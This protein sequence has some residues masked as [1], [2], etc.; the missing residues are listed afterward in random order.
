MWRDIYSYTYHERKY[1]QEAEVK[2]ER[3]HFVSFCEITNKRNY[4]IASK[5]TETSRYST[6]VLFSLFKFVFPLCYLLLSVF[7]FRPFFE[8][9]RKGRGAWTKMPTRRFVRKN[10][11]LKLT[12]F[13]IFCSFVVQRVVAWLRSSKIFCWFCFW[14]CFFTCLFRLLLDS[15]CWFIWFSKIVN[16]IKPRQ[17]R[18]NEYSNERERDKMRVSPGE[19]KG[20]RRE[21]ERERARKYACVTTARVERE[22]V[23]QRE[24]ERET[25]IQD[26]F[27]S[28][29]QKMFFSL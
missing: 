8:S 25:D 10:L 23:K 17:K 14:C 9:R 21:R 2:S 3:S 1:D 16:I 11:G 4:K 26:H 22:R 15:T 13:L 18:K 6:P 20:A 19:E 24:R 5:Y 29:A 12:I 27:F 28:F 7:H